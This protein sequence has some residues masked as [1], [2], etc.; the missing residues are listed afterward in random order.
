MADTV[1]VSGCTC[2]FCA[3]RSVRAMLLTIVFLLTFRQRKSTT[4]QNPHA[5]L[6]G[7]IHRVMFAIRC[8]QIAASWKY[9]I[10]L[11]IWAPFPPFLIPHRTPGVIP[12][13]T[14]F[15]RMT[16]RFPR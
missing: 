5:P 9:Y 8:L 13:L 1:Y 14:L 11:R 10:H 2:T 16:Q 6:R 3:M 4:T 12:L 7:P 15:E